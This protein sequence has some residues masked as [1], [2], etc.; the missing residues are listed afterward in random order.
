MKR[1][2]FLF[3]KITTLDNITLAIRNATKHKK[4]KRGLVKELARNPEK[5]AP[6]IQ[7]MLLSGDYKLSQPIETVRRERQKVRHIKVPKFYP[8]Q[9]IHWSLMQVI[10]PIINR[11][12]DKYCCGSVKTRGT[13]AAKKAVDHFIKSDKRIKYVFKAD[14]HHF[15][16]SVDIELLKAKFRRVIKDAKVLK[17]IDEILDNGGKGLPIGYYTSQA[18]SNFYLQQFDH[19]VKQTL[20]IKHYVRYADDIV[21][22]DTN[23]RKLHK[24][25]VYLDNYLQ[26]ENLKL[27]DDWQVWKYGSR[28]IDFVGY[29]FYV[30]YT[31]LRKKI[32]YSLTRTVRKI[33]SFGMRM[34]QIQRFLSF[35]GRAKFINFKKYYVEH[36]KPIISKGVACKFVSIYAKTA[37][38]R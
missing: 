17:L 5:Y 33:K 16:E 26:G 20:R 32:F 27:K 29:R 28:P 4:R 15:F 18:F 25:K 24:A 37:L 31:L 3:E 36:I 7:A 8:D 34:R 6:Q 12:M 19:E 35:M 13:S 1:I 21:F 23:K 11:G 22:L 10:D 14:I 9:I 2:G 38:Q 30:G